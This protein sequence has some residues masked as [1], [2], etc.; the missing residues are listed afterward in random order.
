[1]K[2][3]KYIALLSLAAAF[4]GGSTACTDLSETVY[5]QVTGENYYN[6]KS[7]VIHAVF[8]PF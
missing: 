7:D 8:R 1:M 6:K 5:D 2:T 4:A 3:S